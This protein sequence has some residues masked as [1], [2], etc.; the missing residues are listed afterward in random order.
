MA[1]LDCFEEQR[2]YERQEAWLERFAEE[3]RDWEALQRLAKEF[4]YDL[5]KKPDA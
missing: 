3:Q 1:R 4:G 2:E 5:V